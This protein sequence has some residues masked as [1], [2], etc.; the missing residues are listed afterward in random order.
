[1]QRFLK[2]LFK[3]LA[4]LLVL[5]LLL[6]LLLNLP[7]TQRYL[8][9]KLETYLEHKLQT[10]VEIG[11]IRVLPLKYLRIENI[12]LEDLKKDTLLALNTLTVDFDISDLWYKK[13]RFQHITIDGFKGTLLIDENGKANYD[14]I[15]QAFAGPD[16]PKVAIESDEPTTAT[17]WEFI[18]GEADVDLK[19]I[20]F[21][22]DDQSTKTLYE[23]KFQSLIG[24]VNDIDLN[25][26]LY[27]I[28]QLLLSDAQINI[29]IPPADTT[30]TSAA[31]LHF[32]IVLD[33]ANLEKVDFNLN[34]RGILIGLDAANLD[35]F[36]GT[37]GIHDT[38]IVMTAPILNLQTE[39]FDYHLENTPKLSKGFDPNH[40]VWNNVLMEADSFRYNNMN[41]AANIH[42]FHLEDTRGLTIEEA[43]TTFA[44]TPNSL[45]LNDLDLKTSR[46][47]M[48]DEH[49][50]IDYKFLGGQ[51]L[52]NMFLSLT[53]ARGNLAIKDILYFQPS[54]SEI[55][56]FK[57]YQDKTIN[58]KARMDGTFRDL[59]VPAL[60]VRL[61]DATR[62]Q[63]SGR[64]YH[65][66]N[67]Q[68]L[69][70]LLNVNVLTMTGK[71]LA[72]WL[73]KEA[74]PSYVELPKSVYAN[75]LI[76]GN[77]EQ[78]D[79]DLD[80][81]TSRPD[82]TMAAR[83]N[84]KAIIKNVWPIEKAYFD[85]QVD[86]FLTTRNDLLSYLSP[87]ILPSYITLPNVLSLQGTAKGTVKNMT[88]DF[89]LAAIRGDKD[90]YI[91]TS[92]S[93]KELLDPNNLSFNIEI[94]SL[95][96]NPSEILAYI[97]ENTL[98]TYLLVPFI[99][100]AKGNIKGNYNHLD[101]NLKLSSNSGELD[102]KGT[103][104]GEKYDVQLK[105]KDFIIQKLFDKQAF[106]TLVG[107]WDIP[108]LTGNLKIAGQGLNPKNDLKARV[109]LQ[110]QPTIKGKLIKGFTLAGD[111]VNQSFK[112][113]MSS[114]EEELGLTAYTT[115][116]F[117]TSIPHI[118]FD[119]DIRKLD[120]YKMGLSEKPFFLKG[121][122]ETSTVGLSLDTLDATAFI[123][124]LQISFD[125]LTHTIDSL[126]LTANFN[127]G[128]NNIQIYSDF[129]N[130]SLGGQFRFDEIISELE[131]QM[132]S[133]F[134]I[135]TA[136]TLIGTPYDN[137]QFYMEIFRPEILTMGL[138]PHLTELSPF[139]ANGSYKSIDKELR[140]Y[141]E[142][143]W[144]TYMDVAVDST[145]FVLRTDKEKFN[146]KFNIDQINLFDQVQIYRMIA[147]G[148]LQDKQ[149]AT[150]LKFLDTEGKD[151]FDI[152]SKLTAEYKSF[153]LELEPEQLIN[154]QT[155]RI[156]T[157]NAIFWNEDKV[158]I[159]GWKLTR[160][161]A[162]IQITNSGLRGINVFFEN[163]D[164]G[165]I[166]DIVQ[167]ESQ[168]FGGQLNGRFTLND[169][170][171]SPT[172]D[173]DLNILKAE[174]LQAKL[175]DLNIQVNNKTD[176]DIYN[177]QLLLKG[178]SNHV[179]LKGNYHS[180]DEFYPI[181]MNLDIN[182][183]NLASIEPFISTYL[184]EIKGVASGKI[185]VEGSP[186]APE[187]LGSIQLK[188]ATLKVNL[189]QSVMKIGEE[190]I[191]FD[192]NAIEFD[193]LTLTDDFGSTGTLSAYILTPNYVDY[194]LDLRAKV[195]NFLV[196]NTKDGDNP[197]YYGK[198]FVN[199]TARITG[200]LSLPIIEADVSPTEGSSLT[201]LFPTGLQNVD[202]GE[203]VVEFITPEEEAQLENEDGRPNETRPTYQASG[204]YGFRVI[205]NIDVNENLDFKAILNPISGDN[206]E[207]KAI[208]NL[209]F[210]LLETGKMELIGSTELQEGNYLF[211]YYDVIQRNFDVVKGSRITWT[212]DPFNPDLAINV[213]Y[214]VKT[215][216]YALVSGQNIEMTE[217]QAT[218]FRNNK[219]EFTTELQIGGTL[220]KTDIKTNIID[221]SK[222]NGD[223]TA[224]IENLRLD[225]S[226]M[227][228]QA[229][230]LILFNG[231]VGQDLTSTS[232]R[233]VDI[234]GSLSNLV[235]QQLNNLAN[236]YIKFVELDFGVDSYTDSDLRNVTDFRVSVKK[237]FFNDRLIV[238][239]DGVATTGNNN[240]EGERQS[241]LNNLT[242]EYLLTKDGVLKMSLYNKRVPD[243]FLGE[244]ALKFG[245]ALVISKDFKEI[246]LK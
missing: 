39:Q 226:R 114:E 47:D 178:E 233:V 185:K 220:T 239:I 208:G 115:L 56:F 140:F 70:A 171:S 227:N 184:S 153:R 49:V 93:F 214:K 67:T 77:L 73:P 71:A 232:T 72:K 211:T 202:T 201:Y 1:M 187:L 160:E 168:I 125:T 45:D 106:D 205:A 85:I 88:S 100:N 12:Y 55:D 210:T 57:T 64:F 50:H 229:F 29:K 26:S 27:D 120:L 238:N 101:G 32:D 161:D 22:Y 242:V 234:Q 136:D 40:L 13:V 221:D 76:K 15:S 144:V 235:S 243:D 164:L 113:V 122:I 218:F 215:S 68:K 225:E 244:N 169:I 111:I 108:P 195:S 37:L 133:Y 80:I 54:L 212:G 91:V 61:W 66:L 189:T 21:Y 86:T 186:T 126:E 30:T 81:K 38:S 246:R 179:T 58:V 62:L 206:F 103:L 98:P 159:L 87:D 237:R 31:P 223:V 216:P 190:K 240:E 139:F 33:E 11:N 163:F 224:A 84:S 78:L 175:G 112:G 241:Y 3:S 95:N 228:T 231:F 156:P 236:R 174:V 20:D 35:L 79:I 146:Y 43:K 197:L 44:F 130:F 145:A 7:A 90:S 209:T 74:L 104:D 107:T 94:N 97:P 196:L 158:N 28:R 63:G 116:D 48:T 19:N 53:M 6:L 213:H 152:K 128:N 8:S 176:F 200:D 34:R 155:W 41:I 192:A 131:Q 193:Q 105:F 166:A 129:M 60:D 141:G 151:R 75:G 222:T 182:A 9:K 194:T 42:Q 18:F 46:S 59:K 188:D 137:F 83:L 124:D 180:K 117:N 217:G 134:N 89:R 150:Q 162:F 142:I 199:A 16:E 165:L 24:K 121:N 198:M 36:D 92:S 14:F 230:G 109:S 173:T 207:G 118:A 69:K 204:G 99:R 183:L 177:T 154:Y 157:Q 123:N 181:R 245:A 219:Q 170:L 4:A 127:N 191:I 119:A 82:E 135:E 5:V 148:D 2:I 52:E 147:A 143:P 203:G 10:E 51:A 96:V 102:M 167:Y 172:F 23:A 110:V 149:L 132:L 25:K 138:I 17:V 65:L